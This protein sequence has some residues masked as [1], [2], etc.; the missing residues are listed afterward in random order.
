MI[1][2]M[3]KL[4]FMYQKKILVNLKQKTTFASIFLIMKINL[5]NLDFRS[6]IWKFNGFFAYN[7]WKQ[8][9]LCVHQRC[10]QMFVSKNKNKN[11][12]YFCK[13]CLQFFSSKNVWTEHKEVC[14]SIK[15]AQSVKLDKGT[16]KFEN[17]F[18]QM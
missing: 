11:K 3:M 14:L 8:V 1:L 17:A 6:K 16:I 5:Y 9:T 15:R 10:W 7:W 18:K 2:I 12:K 4:N 13:S